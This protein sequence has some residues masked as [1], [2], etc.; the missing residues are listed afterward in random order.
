MEFS[1]SIQMDFHSSI[2]LLKKV[3]N[4][5]ERLSKPQKR[6]LWRAAALTVFVMTVAFIRV[7][8]M[9]GAPKFSRYYNFGRSEL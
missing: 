7:R 4:H 5:P 8:L 6:F 3:A 9:G 2:D 1:Q